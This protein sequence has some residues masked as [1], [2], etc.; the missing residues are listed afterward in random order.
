MQTN[1][2]EPKYF[3]FFLT[4]QVS[5]KIVAYYN[6]ELGELGITAQQ[7]LGLGVLWYNPGISLGVFAKKS[8]I[9]KAAA[10][11]MVQRLEAMGLVEQGQNPDDRRLSTL[12]L[13]KKAE[14]IACQVAEKVVDLEARFERA[15]G[16]REIRELQRHLGVLNELDL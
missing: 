4:N 14:Y 8:G 13:T 12:R 5:R 15:L 1:I 16:Q 11:S 9:G 10:V 3:I 7:M 6:R 2:P